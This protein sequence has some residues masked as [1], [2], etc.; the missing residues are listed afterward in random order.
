MR[1]LFEPALAS[2]ESPNSKLCPSRIRIH[3]LAALAMALAACQYDPHAGLYTTTEPRD[4]DIIG[5]YVLDRFDLPEEITIEHHDVE[6]E[7]HSDGT[8]S[9][10]N[11]PPWE[12]TTPTKETFFGGLLSGTGRWEKAPIGTLDPGGRQMWGI[13]LRAPGNEF[14][15]ANFTGAKPPYGLIFTLGDPDSGDAVILKRK[16]P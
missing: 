5:T 13:Y 3:L 15:P 16:A 10:K 7:L 9:A 12:L 2:G 4:A 14:H 6:V 1:A 8:F 11:V